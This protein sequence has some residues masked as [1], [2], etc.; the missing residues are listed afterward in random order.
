MNER[1]KAWVAVGDLIASAGV[2]VSLLF[3]GFE[4]SNANKIRQAEN[5]N[6]IYE[7][8]DALYSDMATTPE[9]VQAEVKTWNEAELTPEEE[10]H[11]GWRLWRHMNLWELAYDRHAEGYLS[12]AKWEAWDRAFRTEIIEQRTGMSEDL[13]QN[14]RVTYSNEFAAY[15]DS[16]YAN[17]GK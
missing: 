2:V 7:L 6:L 13:W 3:V 12:D 14:G 8:Q 15:V 5:D 4:L 1:L 9:L 11:H 17:R 10:T 16:V